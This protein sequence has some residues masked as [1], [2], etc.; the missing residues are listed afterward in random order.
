MT[1]EWEWE[2][3]HSYIDI[4][5]KFCF[6]CETTWFIAISVLQLFRSKYWN[7]LHL[8]QQKKKYAKIYFLCIE[9]N[10]WG[11]SWQTVI[12]WVFSYDG[13]VV[14]KE[15]IHVEPETGKV[16]WSS[17]SDI[18]IMR[19]SKSGAVSCKILSLLQ[20]N[21]WDKVRGIYISQRYVTVHFRSNH[22]RKELQIHKY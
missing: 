12:I 3:K 1:S 6:A 4:I 17:S 22:F 20:Y 9:T 19:L 18:T 13:V 16:S 8:L 11:S 10:L 7:I 5:A 2:I 21:T 14:D 15:D